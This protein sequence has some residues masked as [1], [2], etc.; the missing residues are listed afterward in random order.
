[1]PNVFYNRV[2]ETSSNTPA[3][4]GTVSVSLSGTSPTM[5]FI[6]GGTSAGRK[7]VDVVP[8]GSVA[9]VHIYQTNNP[10]LWMEV[11]ATFTDASPDTLTFT[12]AAVR[13][14]SSGA[15]SYVTWT[16]TVTCVLQEGAR[17]SYRNYLASR[18]YREGM[19]VEYSS[20]TAI[21]VSAGRM[22]I[23]GKTLAYAGATLTSGSTMTDIAGSTVTVGA[24]KAYFVF[25]YDNSGTMAIRVEERDG[26]GDGADPSLDADHGYYKAAS[27]GLAY[28]R[29][30]KFWTNGS[31][32][33]IYF[34]TIERGDVI[35]YQFV[36]SAVT[37]V[38]NGTQTSYTSLTITPYLTA[39]DLAFSISMNP[40]LSTGT[41]FTQSFAAVDGG[42]NDINIFVM[43]HGGTTAM[44]L[45]YN[46]T[47]PYTGTL[48]YKVALSNAQLTIGL[49]GFTHRV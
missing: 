4:S 8:T 27:S 38:S 23:N 26:T 19:L 40:S 12:S 14:G 49:N 17:D 21:T 47:Y 7:F 28:R 46:A 16:S 13:D 29:I 6:G 34:E 18:N 5:T 2:I 39:D 42:T 37:L 32:Q 22:A 36:R 25:A 15:A 24:S 1:M 9:L 41:G 48:H 45:G 33:I 35:T 30:G 31:S 11:D 20:A 43:Y 44:A 10:A 3:N